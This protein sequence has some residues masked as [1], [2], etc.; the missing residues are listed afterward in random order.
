MRFQREA[1]AASPLNHANICTVH[2]LGEENGQVF[3]AME[4]LEGK[5]LKHSI[6]GRPMEPEKLLDIAIGVQTG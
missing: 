2:D 5:T 4:Y 6:V 1:Q 3:I